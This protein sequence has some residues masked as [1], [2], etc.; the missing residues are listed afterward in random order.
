[1][2]SNRFPVFSGLTPEFREKCVA[3]IA[4]CEARGIKMVPYY[5]RRSARQQAELWRRGRSSSE[6]QEKIKSLRSRGATYLADVIEE[7]GPQTGR[8]ATNA[9]PGLSW[10]NWG[11]AMDCFWEKDGVANWDPNGE[12][13]RIYHEEAKKLGLF[14]AFFDYRKDAVHVQGEPTGRGFP[15]LASVSL[16]MQKLYERS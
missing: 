5:G 9:I 13:Y 8:W 10:H 1:M 3:L 6:I 16:E 4:A 14:P 12:G 2:E 15:P 11:K 7:V